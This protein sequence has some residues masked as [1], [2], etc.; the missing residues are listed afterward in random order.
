MAAVK[1]APAPLT[2]ADFATFAIE[3]FAPRMEALKTALR[4]RLTAAAEELVGPLGELAGHALYVHVA[5]HARRTVHP[6]PETW[7]AF[8]PAA[9]GY[10]KLPH[11]ALCVARDG[12]HARVVLKD[13]ALD[14]RLRLSK[15]LG[16]QATRVARALAPANPRDYSRWDAVTPPADSV[17]TR[18]ALRAVAA[19]AALKTGHVDVGIPLG[20]WPGEAA[21]LA[22]FR[23]LK[24]LYD[25]AVV[26]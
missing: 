15:A 18:D 2:R 25:L 23:A 14:A 3:G 16:R 17:A 10:K 7:A 5:R 8:A 6:P 11:F 4:P 19:H 26:G 21:V 13:E 20:D 9:R 12:L 22:A 1:K 24:P